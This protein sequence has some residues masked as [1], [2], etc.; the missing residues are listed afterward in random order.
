MHHST[1]TGPV[2][3]VLYSRE[4]DV[5]AGM[6]SSEDEWGAADLDITAKSANNKTDTNED[7]EDSWSAN[8]EQIVV[9]EDGEDADDEEGWHAKATDEQ[10]QRRSAETAN[11]NKDGDSDGGKPMILV[12]LTRLDAN[13]HSRFDKNS[14]NDSAAASKL[15]KQIESKYEEYA[16]NAKLLADGTVIPCGT[17][18][19]RSAIQCMRDERPGHYFAPIFPPSSKKKN[20]D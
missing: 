19:W 10:T 14:V 6:S 18:V 9:D 15:R 7:D 5:V 16:G 2:A 20:L 3:A 17:S 8:G 13:I 4:R 1:S 12:D 11:S